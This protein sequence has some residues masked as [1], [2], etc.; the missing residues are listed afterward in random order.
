M[1]IKTLVENTSIS[2]DFGKEHGFSVYLETE[3]QKILFDVGASGLF[4]E[5]A[6]K[7]GVNISEVDLV[8]ISHGH[9]DHG[10]GL[11]KFL[12]ENS[13]AKVFVHHLAFNKYYARRQNNKIEYIGLAGDLKNN[14]Q[15]IM[16]SGQF[17]ISPEIEIFSNVT[18]VEAPPKLMGNLLM[19]QNGQIVEDTFAH[20]QNLIVEEGGKTILLA[21]CAHNG[22]INI[23]KCFHR[24]KGRMPDYVI[25]GFHLHEPRSGDWDLDTVNK[26]GKYLL[27]TK[28]MYYTGHCTGLEPYRHLKGMMGESIDYLSTGSVIT[29]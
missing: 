21:G 11:G 29:I 1:I 17:P 27:D 9:Y 14:R 5:N 13:K 16:T 19:E 6:Q 10:G 15:I 3:G 26:V 2:D 23:V 12:K 20:E 7:M 4:F 28:A 8:V 22:I 18:R 24:L 25:G